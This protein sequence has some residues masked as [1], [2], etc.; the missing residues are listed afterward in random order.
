MSILRFALLAVILGP[1]GVSGVL[2][3]EPAFSITISTPESVVK[4]GSVVRL[5]ITTKNI[6]SATGYRFEST[7]PGRSIHVEVLDRSGFHV[8]E[9]PKGQELHGTDPHR[10]FGGAIFRAKIPFKPGETFEEH[11]ILSEE[12]DLSE[13]GKYTIQAYRSNVATEDDLKAKSNVPSITKSNIITLT[14]TP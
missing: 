12:Y 7:G 13:P 5:D 6:S 9:T 10:H 4:V 2:L 11:L 1:L 3:A 8:L 14:I